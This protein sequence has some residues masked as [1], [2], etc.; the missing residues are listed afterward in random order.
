MK[1][2]VA[3][4]QVV[5]YN[6]K[7]NIREDGSG[8]N[9]EG[10][11]MSINPFDETALEAAMQLRESGAVSHV[12]AIS[13]G[14]KAVQQAL[15][16]ALAFGADAATLIRTEEET[17]PLGVAKALH[18][19]L[20]DKDFDL[21]LMGKQAIDDDANQTG[22]M[23]AALLGWPQATFASKI[24]LQSASIR[25]EREIDGGTE[26]LTMPLPAVIT[27]DL[28]LNRPRFIALPNI[29]KAKQKSLEIIERGYAKLLQPRLIT[30]IV[31]APEK[32]PPGIQLESVDQLLAELK[33]RSV[34][35]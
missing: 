28:R 14:T 21:L 7:V 35:A 6:V 23:T 27:T 34:L 18:H 15:R 4:K 20:S 1:V 13:I 32:R 19:Y 11:K 29:I 26:I 16:T 17:Q 3:I 24:D 33:K 8:M 22:Q 9:L 2:L 31:R 12:R 30:R 25:V 10:V 5:D